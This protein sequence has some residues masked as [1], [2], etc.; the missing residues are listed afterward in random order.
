M[1]LVQGPGDVTAF[2]RQPGGA[3]RA[4]PVQVQRCRA[5]CFHRIS[6]FFVRSLLPLVDTLEIRDQFCGDTSALPAASRGR[7]VASN[8]FACAADKSFFAP[9]GMSS[10]SK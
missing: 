1:R 7:T 2:G 4:D 3:R 8:A 9:P 6:K 5:G 10:S